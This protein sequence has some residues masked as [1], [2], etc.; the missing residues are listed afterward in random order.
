MRLLRA[1]A[2]GSVIE[3]ALESTDSSLQEHL[4]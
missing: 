3:F 4:Q 1:V 2:V